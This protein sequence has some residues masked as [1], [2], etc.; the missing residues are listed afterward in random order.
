MSRINTERPHRALIG[1]L[2]L[3]SVVATTPLHAQDT[4]A[5]R[6]DSVAVVPGWTTTLRPYLFL[7]GISGSVTAGPS[8]IPINSSFGEI[9][10]NLQPSFFTAVAFEK[11]IWGAYADFQ[12]ISL[13]GEGTGMLGT[14]VGLKNIIGEADVT[15]RPSRGSTLRLLAGARGYQVDQTATIGD[16]L[17][18]HGETFVID[19]IIGAMG[20][21]DLGERWQFEMRGDIGG[22]GISSEFTSQLSIIAMYDLSKTVSIPFGYRILNYR[23]KDDDVWMDTSMGGLVLGVDIRP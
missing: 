15:L 16:S 7:A 13:Q 11:G 2:L 20:T 8:T 6:T 9:V 17:V 21:W 14:T 18:I 5:V 10:D 19:P 12:Y 23:I 4:A 3:L 1:T 22:F